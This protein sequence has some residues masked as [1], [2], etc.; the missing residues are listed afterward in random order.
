MAA[1]ARKALRAHRSDWG[2]LAFL[3]CDG[4]PEGGQKMVADGV[5]AATIVTPS[6]TGPALEVVARWLQTKQ[7][8]PREVL[9]AARSHPAEDRIRPAGGR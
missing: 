6:N 7:L 5:L 9:L 2:A 8:P 3:G 4:L 1:G